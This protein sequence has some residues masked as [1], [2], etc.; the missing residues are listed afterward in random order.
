MCDQLGDLSRFMQGLEGEFAEHYN[1]RNQRSGSFWGG[2]FHP[3]MID[4][5]E[6]LWN[7]LR[8]IDLNM[9]RASAASHPSDWTWCGYREIVGER[10]R[11]CLLDTDTASL[12]KENLLPKIAVS[13]NK[14][15][16]KQYKH[17]VYINKRGPTLFQGWMA[18]A[19]VG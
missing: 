19:A 5:G 9:V 7:C 3:T 17:N 16:Q 15:P 11:Y 14:S 8:Y 13:G 10:K 4:G 1:R 2:R 12:K 18:E 6:H